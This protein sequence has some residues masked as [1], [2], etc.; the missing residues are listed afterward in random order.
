MFLFISL[1]F[2]FCTLCIFINWLL[3]V[4]ALGTIG[5]SM[6][7]LIRALYKCSFVFRFKSQNLCSFCVCVFASEIR[8]VICAVIPVLFSLS[9]RMLHSFLNGIGLLSISIN[10][11]FDFDIDSRLNLLTLVLIFHFL[12]YWFILFI[13]SSVSAANSSL[14]FL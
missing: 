11:G 10:A 9:P 13:S 8:N 6:S 12:S 14:L 3:D 2:L 5:Y 7:G 1:R 4:S